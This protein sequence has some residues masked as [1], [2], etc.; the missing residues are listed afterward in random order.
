MRARP[1]R[2][3]ADGVAG[4]ARMARPSASRVGLA[5][6]AGV[7]LTA[8]GLALAPAALAGQEGRP[9]SLE[10]AMRIALERNPGYIQ[11]LNGVERSEY[12]E[13]QS[14]G[15][16][17]PSLNA[18]LSFNGNNSRRKTAED[19]FGQPI[20][21]VDFVEYQSSSASQGINGGITLLNLQTLRSYGAARARTD[22]A[23]AS[24]E[25][26]A[27][28]LQRQVGQAYYAAV[29][30]ERL[31]DVEEQQL[32]TARQNLA[33]V[34]EL[35]RIAAK[36]PTDVLGAELQV[37]QAERAVLQQRGA[38]RKAMLSLKQV[39]GV[40]MAEDFTLTS[41]WPAVF[42]PS[43]LES[44]ALVERALR[45][46]PIMAQQAANVEAA[47]RSLGAARAGR[48]PSLNGSYSYGRSTS[49]SGYDA[50]GQLDLP[51]SGWG[52][53]VS[54]SVPIFNRFQ[55]SSSIGQAALEAENAR[56][57]LRQQRLQLEQEVLAAVIDLESAHAG[58]QVAERSA[59]IAGERLAQGQ[60]LYRQGTLDYTALQQMIDQV[61]NAERGVVSAYY[62]FANALITLEE[63]V[64]GTV[65]GG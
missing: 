21:G 44:G 4:A 54:M 28:L 42:D 23:E 25:Q 41:G 65:G 16:L 60:E 11:A 48:Y 8:L 46:S 34:N 37:Q 9:L 50:F 40:S 45:T 19:D 49:A 6:L 32:E 26:Q 24:A 33:A 64:G 10:G 30:A 29:Q 59:E 52:F 2:D 35:L 1:L 55:T 58:V 63:K 62:G 36:Q 18:S 57:T 53:G 7:G 13:R 5:A 27:A 51:N 61:A 39:M 14:L 12:G 17:L 20:G 3:R 56:E 47:E 31:V 43:T 38:A 22:A 15:G